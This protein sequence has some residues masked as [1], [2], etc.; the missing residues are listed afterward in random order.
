[1]AQP[2]PAASVEDVD[3]LIGHV[4][5]VL[6][7][8]VGPLPLLPKIS[9]ALRRVVND[10]SA[11]IKGMMQTIASD[12]L[13]TARLLAS[14]RKA[15][16]EDIR[17]LNHAAHVL[18]AAG[19]T[20]VI[21][22]A[23]HQGYTFKT[24]H[25]GACLA[26]VRRHSLAT[27]RVGYALAGRCGAD[28]KAAYLAGVV[29]DIGFAGALVVLGRPGLTPPALDGLW[30]DI[31]ACHVQ[32]SVQL[33]RAWGLHPSIVEAV[34]QHDAEHVLHPQPLSACV[35]LANHFAAMHGAR[36]AT[37][38]RA[39]EERPMTTGT[40]GLAYT[41]LAREAGMTVEEGT[42]AMLE[43]EGFVNSIR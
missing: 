26:S 15:G 6:A 16:G 8:P 11:G 41:Q 7:E 22:G 17:S 38:W 34:E 21:A 42:R 20:S 43:A 37:P 33:C 24:R 3:G 12:P 18:G 29:H 5:D 9:L 25:Y 32:V 27:A 10:E 1:M 39:D 19:V 14:C 35:R 13:L 2:N 40:L 30:S 28:G 23:V 31:D 36:I 4:A